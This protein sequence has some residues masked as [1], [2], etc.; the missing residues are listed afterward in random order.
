MTVGYERIK[1]LR[2]VG[3]RRDGAFEANKSRTFAVPLAR[4]YR[5]FH[6]PR[7]RTR[8]LPGRRPDGAHRH[9]AR[10]HMRIT[11]PDRTSVVVGFTSMGA[12]K[13]QVAIQHGKLTDRAAVLRTKEYWAER[14]DALK[15]VL[16]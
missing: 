11:W 5:A 7:M 10:S 3:Q 8:W 16:S 15:E 1:G 13:S 9:A 4:L 2:A 12:A 14:L 6:D